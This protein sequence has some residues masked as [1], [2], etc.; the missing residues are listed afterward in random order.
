MPQRPRYRPDLDGLRGLAILLVVVGH[1]WFARVS[2]GVDAFLLLSGFLVGASTLANVADGRFRIGG[3]A[4]RI[5]G[6]L[7][8]VIIPVVATILIVGAMVYPPTRWSDLAAQSISSLTFTQN[9]WLAIEGTS[10]GGADVTVSPF[11]HL[12]SL[13]VQAQLYTGFAAL[14]MLVGAATRPRSR[15]ARTRVLSIA[16]VILLA[17]SF[18]YAVVIGQLNQA[19]A[20]YDTFARAWEFLLGIVIARAVTVVR[21]PHVVRTVSGWGGAAA[22][23]ATIVLVNGAATFPGPAALLPVGGAALVILAGETPTRTGVDRLLASG[24]ARTVGRYAFSLYAWHWVVLVLVVLIT[25]DSAI[26]V[27]QGAAIVAASM[28]LAV[29]SQRFIER[30]SQQSPPS[31]RRSLAMGVVVA[32]AITGSVGWLL[33]SARLATDSGSLS[34]A[35]D[36][37]NEPGATAVA[38]GGLEAPSTLPTDIL[39]AAA[40]DVPAVY[41]DDCIARDRDIVECEYGDPDSDRVLALVG[42]S[43]SGQW[44]SALA[45][46]AAA[47]GF[48][49]RTYL[50]DE[51]YFGEPG[52]DLYLSD[53]C[54]AW[55]HAVADRLAEREHMV[56]TTATRPNRSGS[57]AIEW[58]PD[59]YQESWRRLADAGVHTIA[60]RDT[61]WLDHDPID[62]L[63]DG[64]DSITCGVPREIELLPTNPA[65]SVSLPDVT[66]VDLNDF[67]CPDDFCPAI[68]GGTPVYRDPNHLTARYA[69]SISP[70][71]DIRLGEATGWW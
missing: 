55:N 58:V 27:V 64:G 53:D 28:V 57:G 50:R 59:G 47:R 42:G 45:E 1:V 51:C 48:L 4:R 36:G 16:V 11:Q 56:F 21:L 9:W 71:L 25:A 13:S 14:M 65:A 60:I 26:G 63:A 38:G 44:F 54:D 34:Q 6:R 8:P 40:H 17:A 37:S 62:C 30:P 61:P 66:H 2:G 52:M 31:L 5:A 69:A 32:L 22:L 33:H 41:A 70:M 20:Y 7:L 68:I 39:L 3:F 12:W 10:Y 23:V 49:L 19:W 24:P 18:A 35:A 29:L 67:I 46:I 15:A 43:H